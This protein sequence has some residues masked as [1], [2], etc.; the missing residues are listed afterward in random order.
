MY[1]WILLALLPPGGLGYADCWP[2]LTPGAR[3][4][5][6][7]WATSATPRDVRGSAERATLLPSGEWDCGDHYY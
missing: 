2:V 4:S 6:D 7:A 1:A 3:G 5:D